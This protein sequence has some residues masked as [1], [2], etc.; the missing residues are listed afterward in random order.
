MHSSPFP[1]S[2]QPGYNKA[3]IYSVLLF[4][5]VGVFAVGYLIGGQAFDP[6]EQAKF[7]AKHWE[8]QAEKWKVETRQWKQQFNALSNT[9]AGSTPPCPICQD[10]PAVP[11][12]TFQQ[13]CPQQAAPDCPPPS[14]G[15]CPACPVCQ[16]CPSGGGGG[17]GPG[18]ASANSHHA[19]CDKQA[20]LEKVDEAERHVNFL[21][22]KY[23]AEGNKYRKATFKEKLHKAE[24]EYRGLKECLNMAMPSVAEAYSEVIAQRG[25]GKR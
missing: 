16:A 25:H 15:L 5:T 1:H 8:A 17:A 14:S 3:V 22:Q 20:V 18:L 11:E 19:D 7:E 10:C 21:E 12:Q 4:Y 13:D 2:H 6:S 23:N 24:F 9:P